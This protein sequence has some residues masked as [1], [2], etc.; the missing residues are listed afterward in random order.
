[1]SSGVVARLREEFSFV[2]GNLLVLIV[3]Y[4]LFRMTDSMSYPFQSPYIRELGA[5]PLVLGLMTSLGALLVALVRIPG[6][7]I[8]DRYGRR[9]VISVFTFGVAFSYLF[10]MLAPDWRFILI[11]VVAM[12]LSH[13]Y[14]PAL[15]ALEA[16]SIPAGKRGLGYSAINVLPMLPAML[17]PPIGGYLVEKLGLVPGVRIA[18]GFAFAGGLA[19]ALIRAFFLRETLENPEEFRWAEVGSAFKDSIGSIARAWREM[20]REMVFLTV[21]MIIGAFEYPVF[22]IFMSLYALDVVGVGGFQWSLVSTAYMVAGL[23]VGFPIGRMI[24]SIGRKKSILLA[25]LFSTPVILLFILSKSFVHV[26]MANVLFAI[27]QAFM[28][29]AF[30]ALQADLVPKDKRGRIMGMIGTLRTLAVVPAATLFG[31]LYEVNPVVPF[32]LALVLEILTI[33]IVIYK[34]KEP[35]VVETS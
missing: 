26:L 1:M 13:V 10:Y 9:K 25:Y 23:L 20:P 30:S 8:A 24:D 2:R 31:V 22:R 28:Y 15:E 4:T 34:I 16:D 21:A 33:V 11:G 17:T 18:Y 32:A 5:S 3:S 29:P 19:T 12:N 6:A 35:E 14:V 27:S 7:F